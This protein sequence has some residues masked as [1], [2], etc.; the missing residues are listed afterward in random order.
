MHFKGNTSDSTKGRHSKD[1]FSLYNRKKVEIGKHIGIGNSSSPDR[2]LRVYFHW[3]DD[4]QQLVIHHVG[5]HFSHQRQVKRYGINVQGD[6][7]A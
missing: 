4:D 7:T 3:D 5:R 6:G 1:Y 2:Y